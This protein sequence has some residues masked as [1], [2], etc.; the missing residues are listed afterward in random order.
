MSHRQ[1]RRRE[2]SLATLLLP[3]RLFYCSPTI[4]SHPLLVLLCFPDLFPII[5]QSAIVAFHILPNGWLHFPTPPRL[6]APRSSRPW[7]QALLFRHLRCREVSHARHRE[8]QLRV[9]GAGS[10]RLLHSNYH[11]PSLPSF[12]IPPVQLVTCS[13]KTTFTRHLS[14]RSLAYHYHSLAPR[15]IRYSYVSW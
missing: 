4:C 12:H 6:F 13:P 11:S 3:F 10:T 2:T 1:V 14:P 5:A 7:R 15:P 8:F 9:G